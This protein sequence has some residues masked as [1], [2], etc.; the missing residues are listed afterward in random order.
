VISQPYNLRRIAVSAYG[1][2]LLFGIGEGAIL[3]IVPLSARDLGA[4]VPVAALIVMLIVIG[5]LLRDIPRAGAGGAAGRSPPRP[6]SGP[7]LLS[8]LTAVLALG[9]GSAATGQIAFAAAARLA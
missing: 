2:L 8:L 5:S 1:P 9:A 3:P 4:S 7:A 6:R